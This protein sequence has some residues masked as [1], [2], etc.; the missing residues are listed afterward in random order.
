MI[1]IIQT[2]Q[3]FLITG[4]IFVLFALPSSNINA[5]VTFSNSGNIVSAHNWDY[6][7]E[8]FYYPY[9][10]TELMV[11]EY[12]RL[13][14]YK[15]YIGQQ[16]VVV[17]ND[18]FFKRAEYSA[19]S[20]KSNFNSQIVEGGTY[21]TI[22]GVK[23]ISDPRYSIISDGQI[24]KTY[25]FKR[26]DG[27][28]EE[29]EY[30][31]NEYPVFLV[32]NA[33]TKDTLFVNLL[34]GTTINYLL[35]G[36]YLKLKGNLLNRDIIFY[37]TSDYSSGYYQTSIRSTWKCIDVTISSGQYYCEYCDDV[38]M[39]YSNENILVLQI[40]NIKN[41]QI[42][43]NL[44]FE[45]LKKAEDLELSDKIFN[46]VLRYPESHGFTF[47][48]IFENEIRARR[49]EVLAGKKQSDNEYAMR[50]QQFIKKY[51]A[52]NATNILAGKYEIG[53]SKAVCKEIAGYFTIINKT[54]TSEIWKVGSAF[55]GV[56]T[57][58]FFEGDKLTRIVRP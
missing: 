35:V 16:I 41:P 38:G 20:N 1:K 50:K 25:Q 54:S 53:L 5:Q 14:A 32:K 46:S 28:T 52:V 24:R 17:N 56:T 43:R 22:V 26:I 12:P 7:K 4:L 27:R 33:V 51:G 44:K 36:G 8:T 55:W 34:N 19:M 48:D 42:I 10:S 9:D 18:Y 3:Q 23:S 39:R 57:Y 47:K 49:N 15:K 30:P 29:Y 6:L 58:L 31:Y 11:N 40:Q 21:F 45:C 2:I 13:D 37:E